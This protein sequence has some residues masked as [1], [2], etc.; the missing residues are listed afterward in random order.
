MGNQNIIG[1]NVR[2]GR[3]ALGLS[4]SQLAARCN[5]AG[6]DLKRASLSKIESGIRRVNDAEFV[7]LS[8]VLKV[9]LGVLLQ[10]K[11]EV[12]LSVARQGKT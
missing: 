11:R 3:V 8:Q 7:I 5:V 10:T 4:Q 9:E 2:K 6:W 12:L 1:T